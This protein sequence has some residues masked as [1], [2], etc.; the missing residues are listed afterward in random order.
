MKLVGIENGNG[1]D[2]NQN[3]NQENNLSHRLDVL[4]SKVEGL[5]DSL[6]N[7]LNVLAK[8]K[9]QETSSVKELTLAIKHLS[10]KIES[11]RDAVPIKVVGWMFFILTL[12]VG[13]LK[14]IDYYLKTNP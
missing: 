12:T 9:E 13:G 2:P 3:N 4:D 7:Y 10:N 11:V 5:R 14:A 6:A 8:E 1:S